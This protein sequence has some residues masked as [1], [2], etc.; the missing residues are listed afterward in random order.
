M[1]RIMSGWLISF[2]SAK[3]GTSYCM[4]LII[5]ISML[6]IYYFKVLDWEEMLALRS[7]VIGWLPPNSEHRMLTFKSLE[8]I[9]S[10]FM[11]VE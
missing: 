2:L 1:F 9:L 11:K 5:L 3:M 4:L 8:T 7:L 6:L 10:F